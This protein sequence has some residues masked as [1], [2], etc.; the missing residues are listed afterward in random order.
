L[1]F[2]K[3]KFFLATPFTVTQIEFSDDVITF[4]H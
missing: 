1:P 4:P 3:N 2:Q